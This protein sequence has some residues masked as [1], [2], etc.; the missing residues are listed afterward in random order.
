[1]ETLDLLLANG[2]QIEPSRVVRRHGQCTVSLCLYLNRYRATC[3]PGAGNT[4][5]AALFDASERALDWIRRQP[6]S[7]PVF[8]NFPNYREL[9]EPDVVTTG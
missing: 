7:H 2:W 9:L 8:V 3:V 1:M 6:R 4:I 5:P